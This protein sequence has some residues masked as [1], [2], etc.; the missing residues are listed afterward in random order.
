MVVSKIETKNRNMEFEYIL[1][2]S[3]IHSRDKVKAKFIRVI[4]PLFISS[5]K[6][7]FKS[8]QTSLI[9]AK[10]QCGNLANKSLKTSGG[11]NQ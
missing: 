1:F 9:K 8:I 6:T 7:S 10:N 3:L 4:S 2:S 5:K 11:N